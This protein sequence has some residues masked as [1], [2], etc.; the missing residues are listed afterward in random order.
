MAISDI[1]RIFLDSQES[2]DISASHLSVMLSASFC[3]AFAKTSISANSILAFSIPSSN[4]RSSCSNCNWRSLETSSGVGESGIFTPR[5]FST[6]SLPLAWMA[7]DSRVRPFWARLPSNDA[8]MGITCL[9][10][11][12]LLG[13]S[14]VGLVPVVA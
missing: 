4:R 9:P 12:S 14:S 3:A 8:T 10:F 5:V 6:T 2:D 11:P 1:G 7:L 13:L